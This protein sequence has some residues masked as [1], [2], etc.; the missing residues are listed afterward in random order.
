MNRTDSDPQPIVLAFEPFYREHNPAVVGLVYTLS[1]SRNG[2]EDIAQEAF[3]RAH[4]NWDEV[5]RYDRPGGWVRVVAMNLGRSRIRRLGAEARA[6]AR[7]AGMNVSAFPEL[8]PH[9]EKFWAAVRS[10][11]RRQR[12]VVAFHY[13]EDMATADIAALL[14]ITQS[15]VKNSLAQARV[16]LAK[17][18]E[19]V[20]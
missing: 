1:G 8:E 20:L 5:A 3:L 17:T 6:L 18:L 15:T 19:M 10:L 12:E 16:S 14:G 11:P 4:R 2:A 9:N 13:L 7:F